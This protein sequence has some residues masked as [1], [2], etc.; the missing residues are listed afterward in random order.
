MF[1][2]RQIAM[3]KRCQMICGSFLGNLTE[4]PCTSPYECKFS[5]EERTDL[6]KIDVIKEKIASQE[7]LFKQL[8]PDSDLYITLLGAKK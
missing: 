7:A 4:C 1:T 8:N 3:A 6:S 5:I 2:D